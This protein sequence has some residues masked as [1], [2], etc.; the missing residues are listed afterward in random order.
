[1]DFGSH[2][3]T[4]YTARQEGKVGVHDR[5]HFLLQAHRDIKQKLRH[6]LADDAA[7]GQQWAGW[8]RCALL[9]AADLNYNPHSGGCKSHHDQGQWPDHLADHDCH[10]LRRHGRLRCIQCR[11]YCCSGFGSTADRR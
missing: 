9:A 1:M 4:S 3:L 10:L 8:V 2:L 5:V 6:K 11:L 7:N